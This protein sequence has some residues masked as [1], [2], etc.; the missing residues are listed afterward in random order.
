MKASEFVAE[1]QALIAE[2]GDKS[3]TVWCDV[4]RCFVPAVIEP[5]MPHAD[6]ISVVPH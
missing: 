2:H 1:L 5:P 4:E 6:F 3:V